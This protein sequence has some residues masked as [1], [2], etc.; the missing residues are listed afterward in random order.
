MPY[1]FI[2][3]LFVLFVIGMLILLAITW[4]YRPAAQFRPYVASVL[5]WAS[6]GFVVSTMVYAVLLVA[7]LKAL[8]AMPSEWST[9]TGLAMGALVFVAPFLAAGAGVLAGASFGVWRTWRKGMHA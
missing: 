2:I 1:F 8:E 4:L 5:L 7:A 3:P 9:V 6:L